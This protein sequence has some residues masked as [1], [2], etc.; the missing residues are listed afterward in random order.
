MEEKKVCEEEMNQE[1]SRL[2]CA[3]FISCSRRQEQ[4]S[5]KPTTP[6]PMQCRCKS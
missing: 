1:G 2:T 4:R 5:H 3:G 6:E